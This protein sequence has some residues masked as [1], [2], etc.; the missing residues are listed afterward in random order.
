MSE[1]VEDGSVPDNLLEEECLRVLFESAKEDPS[2]Q[3]LCANIPNLRKDV[4][5]STQKALSYLGVENTKMFT[6]DEV[7]VD[8]YVFDSI[9]SELQRLLAEIKM[10][11][12]YEAIR[13][14]NADGEFDIEIVMNQVLVSSRIVS[15]EQKKLFRSVRTFAKRIHKLLSGI[16]GEALFQRSSV[17]PCTRDDLQIM[18]D[19]ENVQHI[20]QQCELISR[21]QKELSQKAYKQLIIKIKEKMKPCIKKACDYVNKKKKP[22]DSG[23]MF[24][25]IFNLLKKEE[26]REVYDSVHNSQDFSDKLV[27]KIQKVFEQGE[28][29]LSKKQ[30]DVL[31]SARSDVFKCKFDFSAFD[32]A[33]RAENI[34]SQLKHQLILAPKFLKHLMENLGNGKV[35]VEVAVTEASEVIDKLKDVLKQYKIEIK[36]SELESVL[37]RFTRLNASYAELGE[38]VLTFMKGFDVKKLSTEPMDPMLKN[39]LLLVVALLI[40]IGVPIGV[41]LNSKQAK[42]KSGVSSSAEGKQILVYKKFYG[43]GAKYFNAIEADPTVRSVPYVF[44]REATRGVV[45][46]ISLKGCDVSKGE[47]EILRFIEKECGMK[48]AKI[49][50]TSIVVRQTKKGRAY[51]MFS[52]IDGEQ[53]FMMVSSSREFSEVKVRGGRAKKVPFI[54]VYCYTGSEDG[55]SVSLKQYIVLQAVA[56]SGYDAKGKPSKLDF[57]V[58][59]NGKKCGEFNGVSVAN[60]MNIMTG[61]IA[62]MKEF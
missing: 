35:S 19:L 27:E 28:G 60:S 21:E 20:L 11:K 12:M 4:F 9:F 25:P 1:S 55:T 24:D 42:S 32:E 48:G 30:Q 56:V 2:I 41:I 45:I 33:K 13:E 40:I 52:S 5:D 61:L 18:Q 54:A 43:D 62:D 57:V 26:I 50:D 31:I 44:V 15:E 38:K 51:S 14:N 37:M 16:D 23:S 29:N 58:M 22:F 17:A 10:A 39:L 49:T 7:D 3:E 6:V 34:S 59:V 8:G 53:E 46:A 36:K 47:E